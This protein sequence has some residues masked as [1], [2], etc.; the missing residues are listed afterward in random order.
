MF[1]QTSIRPLHGTDHARQTPPSRKVF[2]AVENRASH[3][4]RSPLRSSTK[5]HVPR[6]RKFRLSTFPKQKLTNHTP[7]T[8]EH[9]PALRGPHAQK[10]AKPACL[11]CLNLSPRVSCT[12]AMFCAPTVGTQSKCST[13]LSMINV[14]AR[15]ARVCRQ[16]V[17]RAR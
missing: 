10:P 12:R 7:P 3:Q 9:A 15:S 17:Q 4:S 16:Q 8:A 1:G 6:T 11:R 5:S 13:A 14:S 2:F